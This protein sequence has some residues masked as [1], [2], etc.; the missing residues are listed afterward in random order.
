MINIVHEFRGSYPRAAIGGKSSVYLANS[1]FR[2]QA[3]ATVVSG[4]RDGP[5]RLDNPIIHESGGWRPVD[6]YWRVTALLVAFGLV[7]FPDALLLLWLNEIGF[8]SPT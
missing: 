6:G 2:C 5:F 3:S 4:P 8:R 1:R 7:N